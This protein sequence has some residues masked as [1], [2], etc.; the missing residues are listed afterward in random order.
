MTENTATVVGKQIRKSIARLLGMLLATTPYFI[1]CHDILRSIVRKQNIHDN[2]EQCSKHFG[3]IRLEKEEETSY[4][5]LYT[6]FS[7][8]H[9]KIT[10]IGVTLMF[11]QVK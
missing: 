11:L 4:S 2:G 5:Q 3:H 7:T 6:E 10:I 8:K 1:G 9:K